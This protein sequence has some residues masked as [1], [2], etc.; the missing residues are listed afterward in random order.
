MKNWYKIIISAKLSIDEALN[1]LSLDRRA[2]KE[3][4]I[5][6]RNRL[7]KENH[8]DR[9]PGDRAKE[10]K[11]K[12]A[13]VAFD[14]L[15][16]IGFNLTQKD[17]SGSFGYPRPQPARP[18]QPKNYDKYRNPEN[19]LDMREVLRKLREEELHRKMRNAR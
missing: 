1:I 14:K 18:S 15:Q 10:E 9:F 3:D 12:W 16:S 5:A 11:M 17:Y 13:N 6:A 8:P 2:T 7:A 19:P 4:I